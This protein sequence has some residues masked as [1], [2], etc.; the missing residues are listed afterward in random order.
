MSYMTSVQRNRATVRPNSLRLGQRTRRAIR[1]V[2]RIVN[3]AVMLIAG[4]RW[5][6]IVGILRH[7]GRR[8]GR[9]YATPLGMRP[10]ADSFVM[11][12]TFSEQAGWYQN[13]VAAGAAQVTYGGKTYDV[14]GAEGIDYDT[15]KPAVSPHERAPVPPLGLKQ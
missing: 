9:P 15:P 3:P 4:R 7:R 12:L 10:L 14:R 13:V 5:M 8:S 6:P 11:P 2:A 1:L